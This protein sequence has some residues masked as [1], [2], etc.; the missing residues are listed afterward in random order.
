VPS[1]LVAVKRAP[2][3]RP[4]PPGGKRDVNRKRRTHAIAKA[5]LALFLE[6]GVETVTIDDIAREAEIAKGS[7]YRYFEDKT[8]LVV[9]I[10]DPMSRLM[11]DALQRCETSLRAA[12]DRASLMR[13]Y[14]GLAQDLIPIAIGHFDV[15]RLYLQENRAPGH[16]ARA[17][18]RALA[19]EIEQRAI[20]LTEIAIERGLL[21][22]PDPRISAL[23]VVGA[24][25]QLA[26]GFLG[27]RLDAPPPE[28]ASTLIDL[29]LDGL[30][31]RR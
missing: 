10:F 4:G 21:G 12:D 26:L 7:F 2:K 3:E 20:R 30:R 11:R 17:P 24:I 15:V 9:A 5:A 13:A 6:K 18:I 14:Q 22:I 25:E 1:S 23:A 31:I 16:G 27:G 29:V 8:E 28:V 19:L